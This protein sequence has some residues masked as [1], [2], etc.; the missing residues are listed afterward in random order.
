MMC[1]LYRAEI[2]FLIWR[3][4]MAVN[5]IEMGKKTYLLNGILQRWKRLLGNSRLFRIKNFFFFNDTATTEIY[6][7]SLHD[8]LPLLTSPTRAMSRAATAM[9]GAGTAMAAR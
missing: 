3:Y 4:G 1:S 9:P 2:H 6:T 5:K 8:A 7:L